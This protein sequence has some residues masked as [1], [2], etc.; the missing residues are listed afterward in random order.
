MSSR[1]IAAALVLVALAA[2][3]VACGRR[4]DDAAGPPA[5][6]PDTVLPDEAQGSLPDAST[7]VD[8]EVRPAVEPGGE[9]VDLA[10]ETADGRNRSAHLYVPASLPDGPVPLL[11]ALHGGTGSGMQFRENSGYDGLA[12]ANGFLVVYPDGIGGALADD[13]MRTWN[14]GACCGRAVREDVDDVAF[15][16]QLVDELDDSHDI[17]PARVYATGHSNGMIMSY[18]LVCEAPDVFVAAAGQAGTLG[19]PCQPDTPVSVLHLHGDADTS[20]PIDGG[21]GEGISG[22]DFPSPRDGI[23][24]V[25]NADGCDP[26]PERT[27]DGAVTIQTWTGCNDD[28]AVVFVT[29]AGAS[30]AW[31]GAERVRPR[32]P[33]PYAGYDA[34]LASW[35]FLAGHPRQS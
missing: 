33:E 9:L 1:P 29:V 34:S 35:T 27:V 17:D 15:L 13:S 19:V 8:P 25:V 21:R 10:I 23:R 26:E 32:G 20:L 11:V 3:T 14:G 4:G 2:A 24:G 30:H 7:P 22:V 28:A 5:T 31:M 6:A 16:R 18:R 12:E